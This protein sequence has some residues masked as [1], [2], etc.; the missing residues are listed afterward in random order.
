MIKIIVSDMANTFLFLKDKSWEGTLN[1]YYDQKRTQI[2]NFWDHFEIDIEYID[3][4]KSFGLPVYVFT[5]GE[6]QKTP[7]LADKIRE[8]FTEIYNPE[9][10]KPGEDLRKDRA[11]AYGYLATKLNIQPSEILFIDD[12]PDF[13]YPAQVAGFNTINYLGIDFLKEKIKE[14][15]FKSPTSSLNTEIEKMKED[16]KNGNITVEEIEPDIFRASSINSKYIIEYDRNK[17]IGAA[18]CAAIAPLTFFM[19][20]ENK[21]VF[22]KDSVDFDDDSVILEGAESCPVFAIKIIDKASGEVIFPIE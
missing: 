11:N 19:D 20:D 22:Q 3:Y 5:A 18:S 12:N 16:K 1:G 2:I 8:Y 6:I 17:C 4:I 21:A 15:T 14:F 13:I 10:I 9:E 7:E